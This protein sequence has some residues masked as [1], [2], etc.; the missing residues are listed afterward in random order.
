[1]N[2]LSGLGNFLQRSLTFCETKE[3]QMFFSFFEFSSPILGIAVYHQVEYFDG[4]TVPACQTL[5]N[6]FWS[7]LYFLG[8]IFLFFI[9]PFVILIVLYFIIAKNLIANASAV[10][11][12]KHID[13]CSIRARKQVILMLGTVVISFFICLIPFRVFTLWI[14]IVP[15]E[16]IYELGVEKY[17]N[18]L[19]FCRIMVYLNS[20][21]NPILYNLMSSKFRMGFLICSEKRRRLHLRRSRNGTFSTTATSYRSSTFRNSNESY[22]VCFRSRNNSI[23]MKNLK[24]SPDSNRNCETGEH[25]IKNSPVLRKFLN[26]NVNKNIEEIVASKQ[27]ENAIIIT[28]SYYEDYNGKSGQILGLEKKILKELGNEESFV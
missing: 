13:N 9:L 4:S 25:I 7:A 20:A 16:R 21:V 19:Y 18:I 5:A 28:N 1:M 10:V 2:S 27:E 14:I 17:Y 15:E 11:L 8:S 22:K 26:S 24:D 6:T 3:I 12:N 23:L